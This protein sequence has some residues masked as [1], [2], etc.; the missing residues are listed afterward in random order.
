MKKVDIDFFILSVGRWDQDLSSA[1]FSMARA[2]AK[3][4]RVFYIDHP[5]SIKDVWK[6][7]KD[8]RIRKRLQALLFGRNP[9]TPIEGHHNLYYVTPF[10]TLPINGFPPGKL[11]NWLNA[12]NNFLF[13]KAIRRTLRQ[14]N[15]K[16]YIYWNSYDPFYSATLPRD[17]KPGL[18]IYQSRDN[19]EE[20]NYVRK[21][22]P[23]LEAIASRASD[24]RMATS[25]ELTQHLAKYGKPYQFFPNAAA[26]EL[27]F[28]AVNRSLNPPKELAGIQGKII[29]YIGNICLR[30]DYD[31]IYKLAT[32]FTS[33][34]LVLVGPRN[35]RAYHHYEFEKLPNV[36]FTGPKK[37]EQLP[38]YLA[39]MDVTI[40][41]FKVNNLTKS[42]YPLKLNEY[43]A[44]GKPVVTTR[45]SPDLIP[46]QDCIY[47]SNT[48]DEFLEN[49]RIA[50]KD[51]SPELINR[52]I[53][54]AA[55]N[56]WSNRVDQF[57]EIVEQTGKFE[58][59]N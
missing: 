12:F 43:L 5:F 36:I 56:S 25:S 42:I 34:T 22:G 41:P 11:Y 35:D 59:L 37:L 27:F 31:L 4:N 49:I 2:L 9:V 10:I 52:R 53:A 18:F 45:F 16:D 48:H 33:E 23:A 47:V 58:Q 44:A 55:A 29:G 54:L 40:M 46:F 14:F 32:T 30:Q 1:S 20:S 6:G 39:Y 21:H 38:E 24:L 57:W 28:P 26:V 17:L 51:E 50:L 19:I 15:I 7:R 8:P 13:F 3:T